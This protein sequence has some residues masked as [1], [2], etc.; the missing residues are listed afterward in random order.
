[1]CSRALFLQADGAPSPQPIWQCRIP[2]NIGMGRAAMGA[3][4]VGGFGSGGGGMD[5]QTEC[6]VYSAPPERLDDV[7]ARSMTAVAFSTGALLC[8]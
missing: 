1:M 3:M 8:V 2:G 6:R 7:D 4:G 5:T